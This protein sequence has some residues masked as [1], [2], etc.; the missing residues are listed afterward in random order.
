MQLEYDA[1]QGPEAKAK[2]PLWALVSRLELGTGSRTPDGVRSQ[3]KTGESR[4][5][6]GDLVEG[7]RNFRPKSE[8]LACREQL[9]H[10]RVPPPTHTRVE[11]GRQLIRLSPLHRRK[12]ERDGVTGWP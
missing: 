2:R 7:A 1:V 11:P 12:K 9:G 5:G 3:S 10:V 8:P 6:L 4:Q